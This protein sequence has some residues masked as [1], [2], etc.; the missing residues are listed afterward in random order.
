MRRDGG[1]EGET[2]GPEARK[3]RVGGERREGRGS[4]MVGAYDVWARTDD[5]QKT[6]CLRAKELRSSERTTATTTTTGV[7][8][9]LIPPVRSMSEQSVD[10]VWDPQTQTMNSLEGWDYS[11]ELAY[12]KNLKGSSPESSK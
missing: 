11:I 3:D 6:G 5:P 2:P 7:A 4:W 10:V 12:L 1:R 9:R 8:A